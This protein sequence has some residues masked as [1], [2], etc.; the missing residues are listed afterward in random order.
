MWSLVVSLESHLPNP[1]LQTDSMQV[2]M[3]IRCDP[4]DTV[5]VNFLRRLAGS[6]PTFIPVAS[7]LKL[8]MHQGGMDKV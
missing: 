5:A 4:P 8:L 1:H 7:A 2:E 6:H 3:D